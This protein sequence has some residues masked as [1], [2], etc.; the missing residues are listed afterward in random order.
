MAE[1]RKCPRWRFF[2]SGDRVKVEGK[3]GEFIFRAHVRNEEAE[4]E[5][6]ELTRCRDGAF[7]AVA[8]EREIVDFD[9][10]F[11]GVAS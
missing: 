2:R 11:T 7:V 5:W 6:L 1:L 10:E 9:A 8:L 4:S 3:K